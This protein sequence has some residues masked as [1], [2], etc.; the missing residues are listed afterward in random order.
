VFG[1]GHSGAGPH[2]RYQALV[3][4]VDGSVAPATDGR[5][6]DEPS[7][8]YGWLTRQQKA[9]YKAVHSS[10]ATRQAYLSRRTPGRRSHRGLLLC[11]TANLSISHF[12][13]ES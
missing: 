7:S 9:G 8:F 2:L 4:A 5:F 11:G 6:I 10:A 12:S 13:A 1:C 3:H